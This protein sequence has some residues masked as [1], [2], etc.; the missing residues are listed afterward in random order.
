MTAGRQSAPAG[1]RQLPIEK[2]RIVRLRLHSK[3]HDGK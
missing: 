2:Q 3:H 1:A